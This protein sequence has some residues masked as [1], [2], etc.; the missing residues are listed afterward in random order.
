VPISVLA[1]RGSIKNFA[2]QIRKEKMLCFVQN[3]EL[4]KLTEAIVRDLCYTGLIHIDARL[5][6]TSG[7]IFLVEANPRFWGSLDEATVCGLNF[8]KAGIY[9]FMGLESSEPTTISDVS[10]P[11]VRQVFAKIATCRQSYLRLPPQQRLRLKRIMGNSIR[12]LLHL[13][14]SWFL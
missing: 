11:S 6:D 4:A 13:P 14:V 1:D 12:A 3:N 5:H 9:S 10:S 7:E 8:V 2:V